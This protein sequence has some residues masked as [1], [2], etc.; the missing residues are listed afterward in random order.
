MARQLDHWWNRGTTLIYIHGVTFE[1]PTIAGYTG[2]APIYV[3]SARAK[4][5]E[6]NDSVQMPSSG[7]GTVQ[8]AIDWLKTQVGGTS[9]NTLTY[10]Y[11]STPVKSNEYSNFTTLYNAA[12]AAGV[13]ANI[14]LEQSLTITSGTNWDFTKLKLIGGNAA[15]TLDFEDTGTPPTLLDGSVL[16]I[17]DMVFNFKNYTTTPAWTITGSNSLIIESRK[18]TIADVTSS[19]C[20]INPIQISAGSLNVGQSGATSAFNL[21]NSPMIEMLG[22]NLSLYPGDSFFGFGPS[23]NITGSSGTVTV[24]FGLY[25]PTTTTGLFTLGSF[26]GTQN[27][28]SSVK[29]ISARDLKDNIQLDST[30]IGSVITVTAVCSLR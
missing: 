10:I 28:L 4:N 9:P 19:G 3:L 25:F 26:T 11:T 22:G 29:N 23:G 6:Y 5:V 12:I 16:H 24:N 27:N 20:T 21:A 2:D 8:A 7:A 14:I 1:N 30:K 18:T 17:Q 13:Y 15:I